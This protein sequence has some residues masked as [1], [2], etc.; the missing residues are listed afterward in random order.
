MEIDNNKEEID[1]NYNNIDIN[2]NIINNNNKENNINDKNKEINKIDEINKSEEN[3][4]NNNNKVNNN[5][6]NNNIIIDDSNDKNL[7]SKN[8][9]DNNNNN[10]AVNNINNN[11]NNNDINNI[12]DN[13]I[14]QNKGLKSGKSNIVV[15][16]NIIYNI[17]NVVNITGQKNTVKKD[18]INLSRSPQYKQIINKYESDT[19][20]RNN[21]NLIQLERKK[22]YGKNILAP[23]KRKIEDIYKHYIPMY[24]NNKLVGLNKY[25]INTKSNNEINKHDPMLPN[26]YSNQSIGNNYSSS[27]GNK[28]IINRRLKPIINKKI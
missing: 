6:E 26:I 3:T 19:L 1:I 25:A 5:N 10:N 27:I 8:N 2:D 22:L 23:K 11:N 7:N 4:N 28:I 20:D 17:N 9:I 14:D 21:L 16:R 24:G 15:N 12:N 18:K 13:N